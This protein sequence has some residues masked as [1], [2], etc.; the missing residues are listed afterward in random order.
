MLVPFFDFVDLFLQIKGVG[1]NSISYR[2][3]DIKI[4]IEDLTW[5][6]LNTLLSSKSS[7][8][9]IWTKTCFI[10]CSCLLKS[11]SESF[12]KLLCARLFLMSPICFNR[13]SKYCSTYSLH[14]TLL[15]ESESQSPFAI[16]AIVVD[17]GKVCN[18]LSLL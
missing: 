5:A 17:H 4:R 12:I 1:V 6:I 14:Q 7:L 10:V 16:H 15:K 9:S 2:R 3:Y 8:R 18:F 11:S 13:G